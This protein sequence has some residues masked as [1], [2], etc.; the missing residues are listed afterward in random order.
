MDRS[1]EETEAFNAGFRAGRPKGGAEDE[2]E[3]N[4]R[5]VEALEAFNDGYRSALLFEKSA[6]PLATHTA[7]IKPKKE[8]TW[9]DW[10][11]EEFTVNMK[12]FMGVFGK[13]TLRP[14]LD[15]VDALKRR[16]ESADQLIADLERRLAELEAKR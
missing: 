16:G 1:P 12:M 15:S 2:F 5:S 10:W 11:F 8:R 14:L 4:V 6:E 3:P 7:V 9:S 13:K